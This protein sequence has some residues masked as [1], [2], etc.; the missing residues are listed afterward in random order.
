MNRK[1]KYIVFVTLEKETYRRQYYRIP[2]PAIEVYDIEQSSINYGFDAKWG[3]EMTAIYANQ[4][5]FIAKQTSEVI[6]F[7][8]AL[9]RKEK[10][11]FITIMY[12][13]NSAINIYDDGTGIAKWLINDA[14]KI[15][16][17]LFYKEDNT[18]DKKLHH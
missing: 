17:L 4:F 16:F 5:T 10:L 13:D 14:D 3:V 7:R 9:D 2:L 1:P 8:D 18:D 11:F 6:A 12:E 15:I